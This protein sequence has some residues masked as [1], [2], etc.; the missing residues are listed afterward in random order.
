MQSKCSQ[1]AEPQTLTNQFEGMLHYLTDHEGLRLVQP[2]H[3]I[4]DQLQMW[5]ELSP[6]EKKNFNHNMKYT[7]VKYW[8]AMRVLN[9]RLKFVQL[10]LFCGWKDKGGQIIVVC[11]Q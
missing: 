8:A 7:L 1:P 4:S 10:V 3:H 11:V 6:D 5:K 2:K 9:S